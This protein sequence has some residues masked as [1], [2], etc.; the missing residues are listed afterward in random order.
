M[1]ASDT[2]RNGGHTLPAERDETPRTARPSL[3]VALRFAWRELR[4]GLGGFYIFLACIALGVMTIAGVGSLSRALTE[5]IESE[6]QTILGGD[7]AFSLVHTQADTSER[8]IFD[9]AAQLSEIATLRAMARAENGGGQTLVEV[10][11]IGNAYPLYGALTLTDN[12]DANGK[13]ATPANPYTRLQKHDGVW[14]ALV[15]E[16]LLPRLGVKV[17]DT[18]TLGRTRVRIEGIIDTEPDRLSSGAIFGPRLMIASA[19]LPDTGLI[20]P[21]S[22]ITWRYRLRLHDSGMASKAEVERFVADARA[23]LPDAGWRIRTRTQA[24]P[25]LTANIARFA[26]F[27]TLVGLTALVVGGVG[28]ANAVRA[29]L[30]GRRRV[31][32]TY[33]CLGATGGFVFTVYLLEIMILAGLGIAVGLALGALIP[34]VAASALASLLPIPT[35]FGLYPLELGLALVYGVLTTLAFAL[36]PLGRAS[37][38]PPTA[39]FR[40]GDETRKGWPR[41]PY[42]AATGLAVLA[43]AA[44]AI[45]LAN[46]PR[47]AIIY[48]VATVAIFLTLRLVALTIMAL[49]RRLPRARST[50]VRLAVAN[51]HRRG[52]LTP[53]VVLSLGLG[54][55]LIVTLSLIDGNLRRQ[56]T[57]NIPEQAPSFF[58]LDIQRAELP[59]FETLM[60]RVAPAATLDQVPML[61]GRIVA[62][63]DI[64]ADKLEGTADATRI[65]RGDRGITYS[66]SLPP[67]NIIEEGS[68]WPADYTG[69]PLVSFDAGLARNLGLGLG[70]RV[71]INV[72][73]REITARIANLRE[74]EWETLSINFF[75]VFSPN[76]FAG[77][78]HPYL[79]TLT[80]PDGGTT[81]EEMAVLKDVAADFPT[82]TTI[83]VKDALA[84]V[85]T[86]LGQLAIAIRSAASVTLVASILVLGGA[87]ASSHRHRIYDA[88]ILK[89]L[90]ATRMTLV[91][92][93]ALEYLLI[94]FAT[95]VFGVAAGILAGWAIVDGVMHLSFTVLPGVAFAAAFGA[96]AL[97]LAFGLIG[98]WRILGEKP[99]PILRNL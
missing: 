64:P 11:A 27:L 19:A 95:A 36:W 62:V 74:I 40:D 57:S 86:L 8:A 44:I 24:A 79:A 70:D 26:Q 87:L 12:G 41:V 1:N 82:V 47:I 31:I 5:G 17:G 90:G 73:G 20:Q 39:L 75:M 88:V 6:G 23:A 48:T 94:G 80:F 25:G 35:T 22:L 16:S 52:A 96:M 83:R 93:F 29:H 89:T 53:T 18:L 54:L 21:G 81:D 61:R 58:F 67:N 37:D 51:I 98:T 69:E 33:R 84:T 49:A 46:D 14:G 97:A 38:V 10:K 34:I 72:L 7:I 63:N 76:T 77:A 68:W 3:A 60:A 42:V 71:T 28:V 9:R 2:P 91:A 92:A 66:A 15:E 43:L 65:L 85:N 32:A 45:V 55:A 78:P 99:A 4:G 13:T 59:N 30:D 50:I 56:L